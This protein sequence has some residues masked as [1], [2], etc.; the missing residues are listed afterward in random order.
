MMPRTRWERWKITIIMILVIGVGIILILVCYGYLP[1]SR[2][3]YVVESLAIAI[4]IAGILG[5]SI[6]RLLR[7]QIAEDAFKASIGYILPPELKGEIESIYNYHIICVQH[8][9]KCELRPIDNETCVI[10]VNTY[11]TL[12]NVSGSKEDAKIRVEIDEWFHKTGSSKIKSFG[13]RHGEKRWVA[14]E[15]DIAKAENATIRTTEQYV[16]LAPNEEFV[17][18]HEIEEVRRVNDEQSW[19][20]LHPTLNPIVSIKAYNGIHIS[21]GFGH[22]I[23]KEQLDNDTFRLPGTLLADQEITIRWWEIET[24]NKWLN[25]GNENGEGESPTAM[26]GEQKDL[27]NE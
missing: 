23:P 9:Q 12:R 24:V 17:V 27:I 14:T 19:V 8:V 13:Y 1:Q 16:P 22:R 2:W 10:C 4:I 7:Q 15:K 6:D 26:A 11:R 20:Y 3:E 25:E 21:V 5:L 18:W